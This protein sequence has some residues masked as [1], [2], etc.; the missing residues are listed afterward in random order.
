MTCTEFSLVKERWIPIQGVGLVSLDELF[1]NPSLKDLGG[2]PIQKISLFKFLLA[3]AQSAY[4]PETEVMW[5]ELTATD[6]AARCKAYVQKHAGAFDLYGSQPFLQMKG[7]FEAKFKPWGAI[8][9]EIAEGNTTVLTHQQIF[10]YADNAQKALDL[11]TLMSF[12]MGGKKVD[13]SVVLSKGFA[14]K[15]KSGKNAPSV[16]YLGFLHSFF[17]GETLWETL[18]LN[19]WTHER[20]RTE[21][22]KARFPAGLGVV[23]WEKMPEGEDCDVARLLKN[24]LLGNLVPLSR[25]CLIDGDGV[26][27]T[28][29]IGFAGYKE[30]I[31]DVTVSYRLQ[32]NELKPLWVDPNRR[33]WRD[34]T[35]LLVEAYKSEVRNLQLSV[36]YGHCLHNQNSEQEVRLWAGGLRVSTNA[37]EFYVSGSDD[38]VESLVTLTIETLGDEGFACLTQA[39]LEIDNRSH[40]LFGCVSRYHQKLSNQ[41]TKFAEAASNQFWSRAERLCQSLLT[42]CLTQDQESIVKLQKCFYGIVCDLYNE[43][44]PSSSARQLLAWTACYPSYKLK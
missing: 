2:S 10:N 43:A 41:E 5:S 4:T 44:C 26:R 3:I 7:A 31:T 35:A 29:G 1:S 8:N 37:G 27:L 30:G 42:A 14:G 38:Y 28:E 19:L 13:N 22:S 6:L 34:L 33:P 32:K 15:S 23:P 21:E 40:Q 16:G 24:S 25:F 39:M 17:L 36:F 9:P 12:A 11:L 20:L 18:R